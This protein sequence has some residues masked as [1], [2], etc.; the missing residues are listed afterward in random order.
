VIEIGSSLHSS[1]YVLGC[2]VCPLAINCVINDSYS[3]F[4]HAFNVSY[5]KDV[6]P[7]ISGKVLPHTSIQTTMPETYNFQIYNL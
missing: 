1:F 3:L 6:Y 4:N 7:W 2:S 5:A